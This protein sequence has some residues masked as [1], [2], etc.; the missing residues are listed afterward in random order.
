M[1]L[2]AFNNIVKVNVYIRIYY[3][4]TVKRIERVEL[5]NNIIINAVQ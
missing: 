5:V 1:L 3:V 4:R 2:T